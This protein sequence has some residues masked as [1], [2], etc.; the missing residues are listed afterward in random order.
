MRAY[1]C[2]CVDGLIHRM[3][4]REI[5]YKLHQDMC[6]RSLLFVLSQVRIKGQADLSTPSMAAMYSFLL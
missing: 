4:L 2:L 5:R 3:L 6:Q 1:V